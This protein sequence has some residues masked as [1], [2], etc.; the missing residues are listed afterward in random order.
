MSFTQF[1]QDLEDLAGN[2]TAKFNE[3]SQYIR[4]EAGNIIL[5]ESGN[6]ITL[7][8]ENDRIT[9]LEN[10]REI[11]YFTNSKLYITD[12][13]VTTSLKLGNYAF[14]PRANGNLAFKKVGS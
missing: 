4:F 10:N 11:A 8:I 13:E 7:K 12:A 9:F 6:E 2:S 1:N 5:G 14:L 3:L